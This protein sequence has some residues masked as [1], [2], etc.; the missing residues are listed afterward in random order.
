MLFLWA[1]SAFAVAQDSRVVC[2]NGEGNFSARFETGV[3]VTAGATKQHGLAERSCEAALISGDRRLTVVEGAAE[4][5][6]DVMGADLGLGEPVVAIQF[7]KSEFDK[8]TTYEIYSLKKTPQLLRSFSGSAFFSAAD[9]KLDG[10]IDIRTVDAAA[11]DG[12]EGIP[13]SSFDFV[14]PVFLRLENHKLVDVS[15]EYRQ[16]FDQR[17]AELRAGLDRAVLA[18]FKQSDGVLASGFRMPTEQFRALLM[19]KIRVLEI[20][21]AY[22]YSGRDDD[23]WHAL[24]E[25]WPAPDVDRIRVAI[26]DARKRGMRAQA[27]EVSTSGP[28]RTRRLPLFGPAR[29]PEG[30]GNVTA[31]PEKNNAINLGEATSG[32]ETQRSAGDRLMVA[33]S[34]PI[35]IYM[36]EECAP[37]DC[38]LQGNEE[39]LMDLVVD[40]AG[41][42]RSAKLVEATLHGPAVDA[43]LKDALSWK[44][45]PAFKMGRPAA[46]EM[47]QAVS[48]YR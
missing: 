30:N 10:K 5:D 3:T 12:F 22:L 18:E 24:G 37:G 47:E 13:L 15:A 28:R 46:C 41:K 34:N 16:D 39:V 31:P 20:V 4:V 27:D 2:T 8:R 43:L 23:A 25:M 42:V 19:V 48:L 7:R 1:V 35:A 33:D 38:A 32:G 45:I 6:V 17:I 9:Y 26:L 29:A 14:P 44:F 11:V 40:D 21:W 36:R